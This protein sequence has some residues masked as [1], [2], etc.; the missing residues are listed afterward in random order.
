MFG[1]PKKMTEL[2]FVR[3]PNFIAKTCKMTK[4]VGGLYLRFKVPNIF[5]LRFTVLL[6]RSSYL[7]FWSSLFGHIAKSNSVI[8]FWSSELASIWVENEISLILHSFRDHFR[9]HFFKGLEIYFFL[10]P[11][12]FYMS[13][14]FVKWVCKNKAYSCIM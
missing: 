8:F 14:H 2:D 11:L 9:M 12:T 7:G 6:I 1:W 13:Q 5:S 3:R 10:S 4:I